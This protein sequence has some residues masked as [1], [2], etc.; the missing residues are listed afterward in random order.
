M[1]NLTSIYSN[2]HSLLKMITSK[3]NIESAA[4]IKQ[5]L[6]H[7]HSI[8]HTYYKEL[9]DYFVLRD[10]ASI[11]GNFLVDTIF[12]KEESTHTTRLYDQ[13]KQIVPLYKELENDLD[14][15]FKLFVMG[16]GNY[17]KSTLINSLLGTKEK[18]AVENIQPMTWKIDLFEKNK[19][20]DRVTVVFKNG[21]VADLTQEQAK[22]MID[23]E[24][25]KT[26]ASKK[27]V[28]EQL[29]KLVSEK[30]L[31]PTE[32]NELKIKM[33][34][35][36]VYHSSI[37]EARWGIEGAQLLNHFSIVDT[38][39]LNQHN[40]SGEIK[41]SVQE[42]YH[43]S[44]GVIWLLDATAISAKNSDTLLRDLEESLANMGGSRATETMIAVLNRMDLISDAPGQKEKII[45][46]A[47][48]LF[49]KRFKKI[50]PYSAVQAYAAVSNGDRHLEIMSG[51]EA[52]LSEI[53]DTFYRN[54]LTIQAK[55]KRANCLVYNSRASQQISEFNKQL[56]KDRKVLE[57]PFFHLKDVLDNRYSKVLSQFHEEISSY[58]KN[59]EKD[60]K[61]SITQDKAISGKDGKQSYMLNN[62]FKYT[63]LKKIISNYTEKA[64]NIYYTESERCAREYNFTQYRHLERHREKKYAHLDLK[65]IEINTD[66]SFSLPSVGSYVATAAGIGLLLGPV[67]ALAGA[68][69][70]AYFGNKEKQDM[71]DD[72]YIEFYNFVHKHISKYEE[73]ITEQRAHSEVQIFNEIIQSFQQVYN[74]DLEDIGGLFDAI[75]HVFD[76]GNKTIEDLHDSSAHLELTLSE[77]LVSGSF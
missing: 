20:K 34:R 49:G 36:K 68:G 30:K 32:I 31:S 19:Q 10:G 66:L 33:E 9:P 37:V 58:K 40:F 70:A 25:K 6:N 47:Q 69:I 41:N 26:V 54:A 50:I 23:M 18:H 65:D 3:K 55:K 59:V 43:K 61:K 64:T 62:M 5:R 46:E 53:E 72:F 11:E 4:T 28:N 45:S 63:D 7:A 22:N 24:E 16:P 39:G 14:N 77:V 8:V 29:K 76:S 12:D 67:G 60:L 38:P 48:K 1:A 13:L 21:K 75:G 71:I 42:Y 74:F 27:M 57:Q 15:P 17:G 35:E 73:L 44:D 52:L 56:H 51:R 2:Y